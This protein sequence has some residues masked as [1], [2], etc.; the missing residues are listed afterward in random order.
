MNGNEMISI[1][2]PLLVWIS[3]SAV[4]C[5]CIPITI[6][7]YRQQNNGVRVEN[8]VSGSARDAVGYVSPVSRSPPINA[9][10]GGEDSIASS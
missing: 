7:Y 6:W 2:T 9:S 4:I 8:N 5:C 1:V 10:T 3:A